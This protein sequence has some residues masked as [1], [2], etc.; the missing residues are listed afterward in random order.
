MRPR[1]RKRY[2][3][4]GRYFDTSISWPN[5]SYWACDIDNDVCVFPVAS[6]N[7]LP[8]SDLSTSTSSSSSSTRQR[9]RPDPS[10]PL[11]SARGDSADINTPEPPQLAAS[12]RSGSH[13]VSHNL[14]CPQHG[15]TA[16]RHLPLAAAGLST[17]SLMTCSLIPC[18]LRIRLYQTP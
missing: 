10:P 11:G 8:V 5:T 1:N 3:Q 15:E 9:F 14:P 16:S 18:P 2:T 7:S 4:C 12:S 13:Q 17:D 6:S